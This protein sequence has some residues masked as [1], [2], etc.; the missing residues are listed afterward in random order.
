MTLDIKCTQWNRV[1][2]EGEVTAL[3]VLEE[4]K[5]GEHPF[6]V[7]DKYDLT[8]CPAL[9]L[10]WEFDYVTPNNNDGNST[11]ELLDED[12]NTVWTNS[13][14]K[15]KKITDE[16]IKREIELFTNLTKQ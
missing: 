10:A 12:M 5:A 2:I 1:P 14:K 3:K 4:L 16:E 15:N 7:I 9:G 11:L 13:C 8:V 6:D